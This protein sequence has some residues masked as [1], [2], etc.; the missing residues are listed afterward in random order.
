M[1]ARLEQDTALFLATREV[2]GAS[3]LTHLDTIPLH[4]KASVLRYV[5]YGERQ[6]GFLSA[7]FSNDFVET[8][9]RADDTNLRAMRTWA[10]FLYNA[11]PASPYRSY[12]STKLYEDWITRGG[13]LGREREKQKE[14][15]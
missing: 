1:T 2:L 9:R 3:F 14:D 7:L 5:M 10:E 15:Q 13:V 4:M 6:G 8:F 11:M 12:G